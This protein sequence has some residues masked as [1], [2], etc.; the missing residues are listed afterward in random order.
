MVLPYIEAAINAHTEGGYAL[1]LEN[2]NKA[3]KL[4]KDESDLSQSLELYF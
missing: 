3:H 4:W 2:Y 1:A